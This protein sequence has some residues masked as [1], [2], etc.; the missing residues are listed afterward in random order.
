MGLLFAI[1]GILGIM[2]QYNE[3]LR[4]AIRYWY[5]NDWPNNAPDIGSLVSMV[6]RNRVDPGLYMQVMR[7]LGIRGDW[8]TRLKDTGQTLLTAY[9]Y[10][11]LWR[12]G[13]K[14]LN[15]LSADLLHLGFAAESHD[16]L[17]RATE[18]FPSPP[19]LVRFAV[20]EVYSPDVVA[21]FGQDQ[22]FPPDFARESAKAGLPEEQARNFWAAH[23]ELPSAQ[24]G[25]AMLHRGIIDE[26]TLKMLLR[27]LD[28]MPFWR[29]KI[30]Q[31]SY[32]PLTRV[33]VRRMYGE[34]VLTAEQLPRKYQDIGYNEE[35]AG[36][37]A[38]FT[39]KYENREA[40][41]L[42]RAQVVNAYVD[43]LISREDLDGYLV[44]FG[45]SDSVRTFW[46]DQADYQKAEQEI[47]IYTE[48]LVNQYL[49]GGRDISSVKVDLDGAGLPDAYVQKVLR[50]LVLKKGQKL[51]VPSKEDLDSW[52]RLRYIDEET[53]TRQLRLLGFEDWAIEQY[54]TAA[55]DAG[56]TVGRK[57]L[58]VQT[59]QRWA[60]K[61]IIDYK[62]LR[63]VL[64]EMQVSEADIEAAV[65]EAG[66]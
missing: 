45:Y 64:T 65:T 34:G 8:A 14:S 40:K 4:A 37:L 30:V 3:P 55:A 25:Y 48:D 44:G 15:D 32:N 61:H 59:Y 60:T 22:D 51:K 49:A 1:L 47:S 56:E 36:L 58:S 54:L 7:Y 39:I 31:L 20:R 5:N 50:K 53:Y 27:A 11:S 43:D 35:N 26:E 21:R 16:D 28:V 2:I 23:W 29:D 10:V 62:R 66:G 6:V 46:L 52:L 42:T 24:M 18:Y 63:T 33:D 41:G 19:D 38:D 17:I 9:D 57:Y 12:R 13:H